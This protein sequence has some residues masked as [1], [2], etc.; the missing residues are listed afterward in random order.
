MNEH[1]ITDSRIISA[2]PLAAL[3]DAMVEA[4]AAV[5]QRTAAAYAFLPL[6]APDV[7]RLVLPRVESLRL[8][9]TPGALS[10]LERLGNSLSM[11]EL[12]QRVT[13]NIGG[14]G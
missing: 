14:G 6:Y 4:T 8:R 3:S 13:M 1:S 9:M 7:A 12:L 11:R 2:D 10:Q 5:N